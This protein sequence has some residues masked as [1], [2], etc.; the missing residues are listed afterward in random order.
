MAGAEIVKQIRGTLPIA[1]FVTICLAVLGPLLSPVIFGSEWSAVGQI[2]ALLAVPIGLQLLISPVMSVFVMLG[3]ER[4]LLAVQLARLAVSLTGAVVAQ[5]L[6]GDMMMSVLGF[7]I[8]TVI[9]YVV[10][11]LAVWRLIRAH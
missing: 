6:V 4:R 5:L 3:Q 1:I 11:F 10:T 8:G 9:G 7:A 2:I